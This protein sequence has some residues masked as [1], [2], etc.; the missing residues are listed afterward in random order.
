MNLGTW[1]ALSLP[2]SRTKP[3]G[4]NDT[5]G[6][7]HP[8]TRE[9]TI[10]IVQGRCRICKRINSQEERERNPEYFR[11]YRIT[12]RDYYVNYLRQYRKRKIVSFQKHGMDPKA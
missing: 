1:S 5:Y 11:Q 2:A 12:H 9:N 6:C 10:G 8:K 3:R 7:G 4:D